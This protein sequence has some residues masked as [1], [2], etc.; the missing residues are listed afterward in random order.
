M[1]TFVD[2]DVIEDALASIRGD[3]IVT[4]VTADYCESC[5]GNIEFRNC[6]Y[7]DYIR[8]D[9]MINLLKIIAAKSN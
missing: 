7:G 2:V 4:Y 1:S 5:K 9:D 8:Y 3:V 6:K